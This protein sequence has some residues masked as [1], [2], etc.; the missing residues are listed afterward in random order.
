MSSAEIIFA[1][2]AIA[3][4]YTLLCLVLGMAIGRIIRRGGR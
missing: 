3:L 2:I 4:A 1:L